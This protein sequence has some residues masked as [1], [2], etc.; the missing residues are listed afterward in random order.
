M[1]KLIDFSKETFLP[2]YEYDDY[3]DVTVRTV[4][5]GEIIIKPKI[6]GEKHAK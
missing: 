5:N 2:S 4:K 1:Q 6:K 3:S